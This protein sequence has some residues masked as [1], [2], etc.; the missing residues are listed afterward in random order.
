[1]PCFEGKFRTE[2]K[3]MFRSLYQGALFF[4]DTLSEQ[5]Q[6][7]NERKPPTQRRDAL[8]T[9]RQK[10]RTVDVD[11]NNDRTAENRESGAESSGAE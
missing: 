2:P 7:F 9:L 8:Q 1:M 3:T 4:K 10:S 6:L 5:Q 11:A